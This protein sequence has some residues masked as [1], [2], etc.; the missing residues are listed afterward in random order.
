MDK[1]EEKEIANLISDIMEE[2]NNSANVHLER[3]LDY[4]LEKRIREIAKAPLELN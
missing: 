3:I 2:K 1:F 4:K